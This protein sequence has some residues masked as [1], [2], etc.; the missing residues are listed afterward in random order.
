MLKEWLKS[1]I[2]ITPGFLLAAAIAVP[3]R[4]I[5]L[6]SPIHF[7]SAS[8]MALFVG[9]LINPLIRPRGIIKPGLIFTSKR[10]LKFA[11]ILL[12][13]SLSIHHILTV[14]RLTLIILFFTLTTCFGAGYLLGKLLKI[15]WKLS[16]MIATGTGI[17]GGSAIAAVAPVIEADSKDI[18]Y[19]I[20]ATFL[21]DIA[22]IIIFPIMGLR[23][24]LNDITYGL[25]T[26]TA[27]NDTSSVVAAGYALTETSGDYATMVKLT[28]TL[29]I[30]PTVLVFAFIHIKKTLLT[31]RKADQ[32]VLQRVKLKSLFPWFIV[33]FIGLAILN[34]VDLIPLTLS[35]SIKNA[36]RLFMV[37]ALAAIGLNTN[38]K[39]MWQSG[40]TP[41]IHA[42]ILSTLVALVSLSAAY[43]VSVV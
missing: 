30:I 12:G 36:S 37:C 40:L 5:E 18:A 19:A 17:C 6:Q 31:A 22:M 27:I 26:G 34:S 8:V 21:F 9:M 1:V 3:A 39:E 15:N 14:G 43:L 41:M 33:G 25:W 28:R 11:I 24:G 4:Y 35:A 42:V 20:S 16:G 29:F 32:N 13:S 7:F 38:L 10:V 2:R 23:L